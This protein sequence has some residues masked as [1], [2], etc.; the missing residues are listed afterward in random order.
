MDGIWIALNQF[1]LNN[2]IPKPSFVIYPDSRRADENRMKSL[3]QQFDRCK[4]DDIHHHH[5]QNIVI[6]LLVQSSIKITKNGPLQAMQFNHCCITLIR[7]SPW[8]NPRIDWIFH[9]QK[10]C[11]FQETICIRWSSYWIVFPIFT[12]V[13]KLSLVWHLIKIQF[14]LI[15]PSI[16]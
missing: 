14:K 2:K 10:L 9:P 15:T 11:E 16:R 5:H 4:F 1:F 7:Y 12:I 6:K 3:W 8:P 13:A